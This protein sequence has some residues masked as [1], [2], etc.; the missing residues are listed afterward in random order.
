MNPTVAKA[1]AVLAPTCVLFI[2]SAIIFSRNKSIL[3]FLQLVG[4]GSLVAVVLAHVCEALHLFSWMEW[5]GENSVGHYLD[6]FAAVLGLT[7]FPIGFLL[8][9]LIRGGGSRT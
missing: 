7:L 3:T 1:A 9:A 5:G 8:N 2:G 6:L 4:A